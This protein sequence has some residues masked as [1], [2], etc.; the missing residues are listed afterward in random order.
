MR[1]MLRSQQNHQFVARA[2][3]VASADGHD[4]VTG[5]GFA[6]EEFD[7]GLHGAEVVDVLVAG[8][9]NGID[10]CFAGDAGDRR[11]AGGIDVRQDQYVGLIKGPAEFFPEVL[12]ARKTDAAERAPGCG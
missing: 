8:F 2:A 9:S 4:G 12:G 3:D 5:P 11:L 6:Q 1:R 7:S 10:E